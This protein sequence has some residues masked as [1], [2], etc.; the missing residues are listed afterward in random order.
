[1][2]APCVYPA[3]PYHA[4][5]QRCDCVPVPGAAPLELAAA[6]SRGGHAETGAGAVGMRAA[7]MRLSDLGRLPLAHLR[8]LNTHAAQALDTANAVQWSAPRGSGGGFAGGSVACVSAFAFQGTNAHAVLC[9]T[10]LGTRE[11]GGLP[12]CC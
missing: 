10:A 12:Q 6:K 2:S 7:A 5:L 11:R 1:M 3:L 8:S 9:R 4:V